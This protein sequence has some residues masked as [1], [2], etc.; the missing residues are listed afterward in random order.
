MDKISDYIIQHEGDFVKKLPA[1]KDDT[2]WSAP[3]DWG[4]ATDASGVDEYLYE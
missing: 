4:V 2:A 1:L 3:M